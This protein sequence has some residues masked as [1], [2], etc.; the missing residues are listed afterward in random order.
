MS[1]L[2]HDPGDVIHGCRHADKARADVAERQQQN[3]Y[4]L[5][6]LPHIFQIVFKLIIGLHRRANTLAHGREAEQEHAGAN[7]RQHGHGHLV[8]F[9]FVFAAEPVGHRQQRQRQQQRGDTNHHK[10]IRLT[11]HALFRIVSDHAPQRAVRN[12]NGRIGQ[13]EQE[14]GDEGIDNFAVIGPVRGG[15][16]QDAEQRIGEGDP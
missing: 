9:G 2:A 15:K 10:A 7:Q 13:G 14:V 8:A 1:A 12:V 3:A 5:V 11:G 16:H 6:V 4:P